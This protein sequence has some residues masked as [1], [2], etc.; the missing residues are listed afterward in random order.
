MFDLSIWFK[1]HFGLLQCRKRIHF[2]LLLNSQNLRG[3]RYILIFKNFYSKVVSFYTF[4]GYV[5][6][7]CNLL[8]TIDVYSFWFAY[9]MCK[10]IKFN[11]R[12][13][14]YL[15]AEKQLAYMAGHRLQHHIFLW[16]SNIGGPLGSKYWRPDMSIQHENSETKNVICKSF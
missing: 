8:A 14:L 1:H 11:M 4:I 7:I 3:K 16:V 6:A 5:V 15:H 2:W 12:N 13:A 10:I 9:P